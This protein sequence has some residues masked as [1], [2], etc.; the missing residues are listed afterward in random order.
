M[1]A[2]NHT[3]TVESDNG[4][5]DQ[6]DPADVLDAEFEKTGAPPQR[7]LVPTY[8]VPTGAADYWVRKAVP[9]PRNIKEVEKR[10]LEEADLAGDDFYYA[11]GK[12]D[13][14]V[15]GGS[16]A[17]AMAMGRCYGNCVCVPA[18]MQETADAYIFES[19][20]IDLET[21][22]TYGR[23]FR[24]SKTWKV[25]GKFDPARKE[26]MRFNI[27]Q[28]KS[29]RNTI[30][31]A[32]PEFLKN[33]AIERAKEGVRNRIDAFIQKHGLAAATD[34]AIA[35]LAKEGV[36][37]ERVLFHCEVADVTA[38]DLDKLVELKGML[39]AIQTGEERAESLFPP[40]D[41]EV[42]AELLKKNEQAG[43]SVLQA[44][45][46]DAEKAFGVKAGGKTPEPPK[47]QATTE[48]PKTEEPRRTPPPPRRQPT[49]PE[50]PINKLNVL[51]EGLKLANTL[52]QLDERWKQFFERWQ[53]TE[54]EYTQADQ[55]FHDH[56]TRIETQKVTV[57]EP[58]KKPA[59]TQTTSGD[60]SE[61]SAAAKE[62]AQ[63]FHASKT[64]KG[65]EKIAERASQANPPFNA[66]DMAFI[67]LQAQMRRKEIEAME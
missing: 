40:T 48:P 13:N 12:G 64:I 50:E 38:L 49:P 18:P 24:Q 25:H 61:P 60:P 44:Q 28:S 37:V 3:T 35:A 23:Q 62:Y 7:S 17:L 41:A 58:A 43:K 22:F 52:E 66:V 19:H 36:P 57:A 4:E 34:A 39:R 6:R 5:Y 32:L 30:L 14:R 26:D 67:K 10:L 63:Q 27:G 9:N 42:A 53:L 16:I 8:S 54:A 46:A 2:R 59:S 51:D 20:F 65:I 56:A 55:L 15:E 21:G 47:T 33:K 11:W 45:L 31:R 29:A 1:N